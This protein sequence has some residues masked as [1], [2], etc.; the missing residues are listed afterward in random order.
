MWPTRHE[1]PPGE[2]KI[3]VLGRAG[4]NEAAWS[5]KVT[6]QPSKTLDLKL[7]EPV[8]ACFVASP[9]FGIEFCFS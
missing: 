1:I 7:G 9:P 3:S 8:Y 2:Y 6:V 5:M 4:M